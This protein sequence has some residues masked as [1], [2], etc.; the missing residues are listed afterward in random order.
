MAGKN[1][2]ITPHP[3]EASRLSGKSADEILSNTV[4][5][6][7]QLAKD[8]SV[9]CLLKDHHTVITDG[10]AAYVNHSGNAGMASAGMGDV[11]AGIIGALT[12]KYQADV[13]H[14]TL[15]EWQS[16]VD[17]H[18]TYLAAVGAYLHGLSGDEAA[19]RIGQYSLVASDV[20]ESLKIILKKI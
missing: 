13:R 3:V 2:I 4:E 9:V 16:E 6:A 7:T 5:V 11:L 10:G 19:Q 8:L 14:G 20:L 1:V 18:M 12:A 17:S 15:S